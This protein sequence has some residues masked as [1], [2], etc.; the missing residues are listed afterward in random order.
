MNIPEVIST[1]FPIWGRVKTSEI[2]VQIR[3]IFTSINQLLPT[4]MARVIP[5]LLPSRPIKMVHV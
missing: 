4:V 1:V 5:V 3:G 2:T